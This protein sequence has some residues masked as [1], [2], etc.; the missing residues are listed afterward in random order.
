MVDP[1]G[2]LLYLRRWSGAENLRR[3]E[4]R[5]RPAYRKFAIE[6]YTLCSEVVKIYSP[7]PQVMLEGTG[8]K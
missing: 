2:V 3:F 7:E 6:N 1:P 5:E 4:L 8:G